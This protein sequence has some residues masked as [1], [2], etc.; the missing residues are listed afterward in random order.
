MSNAEKCK[1]PSEG[2]TV[3]VKQTHRGR[4]STAGSTPADPVTLPEVYPAESITA[5]GRLISRRLGGLL[6]RTL[7]QS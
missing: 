5:D 7:K 4:N 1:E 6:C 3:D 2:I